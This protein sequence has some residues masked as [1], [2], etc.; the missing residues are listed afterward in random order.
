MWNSCIVTALLGWV[1]HSWLFRKF[2]SGAKFDSLTL[3]SK[4]PCHYPSHSQQL[5]QWHNRH[6]FLFSIRIICVIIVENDLHSH[7]GLTQADS[8]V[9][10]CPARIRETHYRPFFPK[11]C[12]HLECMT[13]C[14]DSYRLPLLGWNTT[15]GGSLNTMLVPKNYKLIYT[16]SFHICELSKTIMYCMF[17]ANTYQLQTHPIMRQW[18]QMTSPH[19]IHS[20][21]HRSPFFISEGQ[22]L[23]NSEE[24]WSWQWCCCFFIFLICNR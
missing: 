10:V 22:L 11:F 1:S 17:V 9:I 21:H 19:H 24:R 16:Q 4:V 5:C 12:Q 2:K 23:W 8:L 13:L 15:V 3:A 6:F 20:G 18:G 14:F 7:P